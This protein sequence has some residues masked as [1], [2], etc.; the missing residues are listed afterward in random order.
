MTEAEKQKPNLN[1]ETET[2]LMRFMQILEGI[3]PDAAQTMNDFL[4]MKNIV[5]RSNLATR[6]DVQLIVYLD[7]CSDFYFSEYPKNPFS[8]ARDSIARA[9]LAKGGFKSNQFVELMRNQPDLSGMTTNQE[10]VK[11]TLLDKFL[12]RGKE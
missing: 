5:E 9:F 12:G 2:A 6:R 3:N 10:Q 11:R 1:L 7:L 4:D 8:M